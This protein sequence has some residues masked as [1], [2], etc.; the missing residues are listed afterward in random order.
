MKELLA[1]WKPVSGI[2][3]IAAIIGGSGGYW[4][5]GAVQAKKDL[6][7]AH[8]LLHSEQVARERQVELINDEVDRANRLARDLQ[9]ARQA[10]NDAIQSNAVLAASR[11][12]TTTQIIRDGEKI[13]SELE[14]DYAWIRNEW[15]RQLRDY[16]NGKDS[17]TDMPATEGAGY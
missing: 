12:A 14:G 15:P 11:A 10:L 3:L 16:A 5:S 17:G 2:S 9:D 7:T 4:L 1:M 6:K 8:A 13:G